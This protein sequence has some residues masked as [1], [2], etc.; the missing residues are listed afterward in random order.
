VQLYTP[1]NEMYICAT[2]SAA[3]GWWNEQM[4]T[5]HGF[6]T[7]LTHM[8]QANILAE[9]AIL[10]V[11]PQAYFIQSEASEYFHADHPSVQKKADQLNQRRFLSL[12]LLYGHQEVRYSLY[13][14]LLDNGMSREQFH[15]FMEHGDALKPHHI[16]GTDYYVSNEHLVRQDGSVPSSGEIFGYYVITRQYWERYHLPVMHTETNLAQESDAVR[17]L[18]KEWT[19]MLRLKKDGVPIIGFTWYSLID[20]ID[21]DTALREKNDHVNAVGLCDLDRSIRPVGEAYRQLVAQW[22][23]I[24]PQESSA[25]SLCMDRGRE[26]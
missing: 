21:W 6:V 15:W 19:N 3:Y 11:Q 16:M 10:E 4:T 24:L 20:Q 7:A 18:W 1:V 8:V 17:W 9:Q 13:E 26:H 2:F 25:L 5:D 22:R 12:D 23:E 14:Y